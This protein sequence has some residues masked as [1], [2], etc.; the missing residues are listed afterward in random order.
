MRIGIMGIERAFSLKEWVLGLRAKESVR[1]EGLDSQ[2]DAWNPRTVVLSVGAAVCS[3]YRKE[4]QG[5]NAFQEGKKR[6]GKHFT[7]HHGG[8]RRGEG[9]REVRTCGQLSKKSLTRN[10]VKVNMF[11]SFS[12]VLAHLA[13]DKAPSP[14]RCL[15]SKGKCGFPHWTL[16]PL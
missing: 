9:E 12:T 14:A 11:R 5:G 10:L 4:I 13:A 16:E 6:Q 8:R 2:E 15:A 1:G 7:N 3:E